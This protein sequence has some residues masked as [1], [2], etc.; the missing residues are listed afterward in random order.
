MSGPA[1]EV[2][3]VCL[4]AAVPLWML[5]YQDRAREE[6]SS[7]AAD[8]VDAITAHGDQLMF[9]GSECADTFNRLAQA[10]AVLALVYPAGVD[11]AGRHWG[12]PHV[13]TGEKEVLS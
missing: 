3:G 1:D 7:L 6:L 12:G 4:D 10:V 2:L 11:F 9:G 8:A 5:A 13:V